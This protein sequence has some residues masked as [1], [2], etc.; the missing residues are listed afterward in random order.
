MCKAPASAT[1][2]LT[3]TLILAEN[4][5]RRGIFIRNLSNKTISIAFCNPAELNKGIT[6]YS[7]ESY[8][9]SGD[10]FSWGPVYAISDGASS[11]IAIQE[12]EMAGGVI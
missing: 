2:G 8:S 6:L 9:M 4:G 7:K 11:D 12:F 5:L 1:I 3:S 10:D